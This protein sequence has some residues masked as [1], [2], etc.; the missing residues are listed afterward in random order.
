MSESQD[1]DIE[2][3]YAG[4]NTYRS[5]GR[6]APHKPLLLAWSIARCLRG[7][8]RL[9]P[10]AFAQPRV[11]AMLDAFGPHRRN[12]RGAEYPFWRLKNDER[13]WEIDAPSADLVNEVGQPSP[14]R[15]RELGVRAGL[16]S[17]DYAYFFANPRTAWR[18]AARLI[19]DHFPE[20]LRD[21]VLSAAGFDR[22]D[23]PDADGVPALSLR[24]P[25]LRL[26]GR[27]LEIYG[28]RC[29][30]CGFGM[31]V[32]GCPAALDAARLRWRSYAGPAD[33]RNA[34]CL[35]AVHRAAFD[36]GGFTLRRRGDLLVAIVSSAVRGPSRQALRRHHDSPIAVP[37]A[38]DARL[39]Q[40]YVD[41]HNREVFR[42]PDELGMG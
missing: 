2:R 41:W 9:V 31:T 23:P 13:L 11:V 27:V 28:E 42:T 18:V 25:D 17:D 29:A 32:S 16:S 21:A 34:L 22:A 30:V 4:I 36:A 37:D 6:R 26:R 38:P 1:R 15:L 3:R 14:R 40:S 35:C 5:G 7:E 33:P 39:E 12:R 10:F 19:D 20:S 8:E 24:T